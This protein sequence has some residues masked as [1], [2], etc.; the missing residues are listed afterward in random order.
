MNSLK[1]RIYH[2]MTSSLI[3]SGGTIFLVV[4]NTN[5]LIHGYLLG[6]GFQS[7]AMGRTS[8]AGSLG[9]IW[10]H[11]LSQEDSVKTSV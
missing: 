9:E 5:T 8:N 7:L 10:E 6:V 4:R 1:L 11:L 3:N 2:D